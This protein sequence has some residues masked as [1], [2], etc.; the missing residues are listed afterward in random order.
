MIDRRFGFA[1]IHVGVEFVMKTANRMLP[2]KKYG[3]NYIDV[4]TLWMMLHC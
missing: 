2:K 3:T 1:R 4:V